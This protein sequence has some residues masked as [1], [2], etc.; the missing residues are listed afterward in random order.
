MYWV[1]NPVLHRELLNNLRS[2]RSFLMLLGYQA[3]LGL[4]VILAW[5]DAN[6][7]LNLTETPEATR[8][9][10]NIF[11]LSQ[12]IL[13]SLIAPSF[14]AGSIA[15]EKDRK[16]YEMLLASPLLPEKIVF[17]K[18]VASLI[19]VAVLIFSSL[20]IVMLCLP[21][22]GVSFYE[23]VAAYSGMLCAVS[24]F[25]MVSVACG[26]WFRRPAASLVVSYLIILPFALLLVMLWQATSAEGLTR[27]KISVTAVPGV[28]AGLIIILFWLTS[29]RL[30]YPQD[31]GSEGKEV[32]DPDI[33]A[34]R[35]FGMV[36]HADHFPDNLFAPK[37][38]TTLIP[39]GT[40]PVLDKELR[41]DI[42]GQGTLMLRL[43]IQ[44]SICLAI[45]LM[46]MLLFFENFRT[47]WYVCYVLL[48]SVLVGPVFS[49]GSLT[50]ER[51]RQ[52]ID[53]LRTTLLT[54]WQIYSGKLLASLR[55]SSVLTAFLM[56]PMVLA[57]CFVPSF[58]PSFLTLFAYIVIIG[59][60]CLLTTTTALFLSS[61]FEK[62]TT[63]LFVSYL[64]IGTLFFGIPTLNFLG[65]T[66]F[67]ETF[68]ANTF[69]RMSIASPFSA[70]FEFPLYVPDSNDEIWW[71]T[72]EPGTA[73]FLGW[74]L[75]PMQHF[76]QFVLFAMLSIVLMSVFTMYRLTQ[77]WSN[78]ASNRDPRQKLADQE[79]D[80]NQMATEQDIS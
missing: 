32:V 1:D 12:F 64:F 9:L 7:R 10:V 57:F 70:T 37:K 8:S 39:D 4:I 63:S 35:A 61:L 34:S 68:L 73:T 3:I 33:E 59:L 77:R 5:P 6:A 22:G 43:T 27:F 55:V 38:R 62:T 21:L 67:P 48:F 74:P 75:A 54:P 60:T 19:H 52:T 40:N 20:P 17:G 18:L 66:F 53:L 45:I 13:A 25:G 28:S 46:P 71:E 42:F 11:F 14:A 2:N 47:P 78:Q 79:I 69:D 51:E 49:A 30:L 80:P 15:G 23:V 76:F 31:M 29:A 36:I 50:S 16:T 56:P 24:L 44:I 65:T 26:T 41:S 58:H 72:P